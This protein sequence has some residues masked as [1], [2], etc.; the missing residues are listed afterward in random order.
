M[1]TFSFS[2]RARAVA[3]GRTLKPMTMALE[4]EAN[5]TSLSETAPTAA[6]MQWTRTSSLLSFS[7]DCF[8]ASAEPCTSALTMMFS[9]LRSPSAIWLNSSSKDTFCMAL[10]W[11]A[12]ILS[13]RSSATWRVSLSASATFITSPASGTSL[14]PRISTGVEG[15][16]LFTVRPL[17]SIMARMRP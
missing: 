2:A 3:S 16:A 15:P 11:A 6:W 17:S 12:L 7:R 8:T 13:L 14:K 1:S 5:I 4:A 9:S 10:I